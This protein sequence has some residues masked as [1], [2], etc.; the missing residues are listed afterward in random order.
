MRQISSENQTALAARRLVARDFLWIVAR[1]RNN[2]DPI[3]VGFWSDLG[4]ISTYVLDPDTLVQDLRPF[5]GAGSLISIGDIPAVSTI[6]VQSVDIVMSQ[7][8]DQV[9]QAV[10][11]YDLKQARVE[12]Y[13]GLF[14]PD[15]RK[16]VAPA[17]NRFVGFIDTVEINTPAENQ[18]GG[19]VIR[20]SSH[21]QELLRSNPA[22]RSD[23][24]QKTRSPTDGFFKDVAVVGD[25]SRQW[26]PK[27]GTV[28]TVEQKQGLFG[29]G[30]LFGFL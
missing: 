30:N 16:L 24:D 20:C 17:V 11:D 6:S 14:D 10:R 29:W 8:D 27:T 22:T 21:T 3:P 19:V 5:Y 23:D 1:D 15:T 9:S 7:L 13:R 12:I 4:N 18:D 26:G 25:W 28:D 2:G